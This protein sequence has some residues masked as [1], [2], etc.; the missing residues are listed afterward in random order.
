MP[1][2]RGGNDLQADPCN[3]RKFTDACIYLYNEQQRCWNRRYTGIL[4]HQPIQMEISR[5]QWSDGSLSRR[6]CAWLYLNG[7]L[8]IGVIGTVGSQD[9]E[10][11]LSFSSSIVIVISA[12]EQE[13]V[14]EKSTQGEWM[15]SH[16]PVLSPLSKAPYITLINIG[17]YR[18]HSRSYWHA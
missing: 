2:K 17:L 7:S 8:L 12:C 1:L 13:W 3:S 15:K 6:W 16:L 11:H 18:Q 5:N 10:I 9:T 4:W 14:N